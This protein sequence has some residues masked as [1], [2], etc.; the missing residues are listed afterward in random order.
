MGQVI[1][2]CGESVMVTPSSTETSVNCPSC[3]NLLTVHG[4]EAPTLMSDKTRKKIDDHPEITIDV[5]QHELATK[6]DKT[7]GADFEQ[8]ISLEDPTSPDPNLRTRALESS[9]PVNRRPLHAKTFGDYELVDEIA[10]G[11]MGVVYKAKQIRLN[12]VVA[13]KMILAGQLASS[14]EIQ[15][16]FTEAEAAAN[17]DH[18][19]IVPIYEIGEH[20]G[21]HFF[22]MAYIEGD[23]LSDQV[24]EGP[25]DPRR[26]AALTRQVADAI[27]YAHQQGVVHRDL[28]PANV[29]MDRSHQ[30]KITD[31]GLAKR[32]GGDSQLTAT[33][34][35]M[36]TPSY[37]PPEQADGRIDEVGPA[38]DIYSLGALLY[39]LLVGRPPFQ[40][41]S[42]IETLKQVLEKEPVSPRTLNSDVDVD[43]ATICLKCLEKAPAQRYATAG[44]LTAELDRYLAGQPILARPVSRANQI[45]RWCRR[46]PL[47]AGLT[48]AVLLLLLSIGIAGPMVAWRQADLRVEA[49]RA[50]EV[51][52]EASLKVSK[53]ND[54][55]VIAMDQAETAKMAAEAAANQERLAKE[56]LD[57][58]K[59]E[60]I[61]TL[62]ATSIRLAQR[63]WISNNISRAQQILNE[64]PQEF[65]NWEW[66]YLYSLCQTEE[67][68]LRG[69]AAAVDSLR[70]LPDNQRLVSYSQ[71]GE[72]KLWSLSGGREL[73]GFK[74][75]QIPADFGNSNRFSVILSGRDLEILDVA[76]SEVQAS[77]PVP[78]S[79]RKIERAI[80]SDDGSLLL[81]LVV[82]PPDGTDLR[83]LILVDVA[84]GTQRTIAKNVKNHTLFRPACSRDGTQVAAL[85]DNENVIGIWDAKSGE[86]IQALAG[87]V[88]PVSSVDFSPDGR[89]LASTGL[90]GSVT[91]WDL[92]TGT[93]KHRMKGHRDWV[94]RANFSED[95]RWLVTCG[96]D[97]TARIW[98]VSTGEELIVIRGN[99]TYVMD[100]TISSDGEL[101]A[102]AS[103]DQIVRVWEVGR[104]TKF[105]EGIPDETFST[106]VSS[107]KYTASQRE[108]IRNGMLRMLADHTSQQWVSW[109]GHGGPLTEVEFIPGTNRFI[110]GGRDKTLKVWSADERGQLKSFD[111]PGQVI[112]VGASPDGK[113]IVAAIGIADQPNVYVWDAE[114]FE[115]IHKLDQ[116]KDYAVRIDVSPDGRYLACGGQTKQLNNTTETQI[117]IWDLE[118]GEVHK[119]ISGNRGAITGLDFSP[120][121][122]HLLAAASGGT[123]HIWSIDPN[124]D[125]PQL[126]LA[127]SAT[128]L[129]YHPDGDRFASAHVDGKVRIWDVKTGE[130]IGELEGARTTLTS[131][132]YSPDGKRMIVCG[133][134]TAVTL[135]DPDRN[136]QLLE[137]RGH[138]HLV[139]DVAFSDDGN[140]IASASYDGAV[141]LW[142]SG[143]KSVSK[144]REWPVVIQE[145]FGSEGI[146]NRWS[147]PTGQWSVSEGRLVG[148]LEKNQTGGQ[149]VTVSV[150]A[151]RLT[152]ERLPESL[153]ISFDF[154][155][156]QPIGIQATL[157]DGFETGISVELLS[158]ENPY[159]LT[160]GAILWTRMGGNNYIPQGFN[161]KYELPVGRSVN[162]RVVFDAG[163]LTLYVDGDELT[164]ARIRMPRIPFLSIQGI[165]AEPGTSFSIDNVV[166]RAPIEAFQRLKAEALVDEMFA[167]LLLREDVIEK[168]TH[169]SSLDAEIK[170]LAIE[171][172]HE[173][174]LPSASDLVA[175]G[176]YIVSKNE[177][178][179]EELQRAV[180]LLQGPVRTDPQNGYYNTMLGQAYLGLEEYEKALPY[181]L[182]TAKLRYE[183]QGAA[184]P[185]QLAMLAIAYSK[186]GDQEKVDNLLDRLDPFLALEHWQDVPRF[187][188]WRGQATQLPR[189][190]RRSAAEQ[191]VL[192]FLIKGLEWRFYDLDIDRYSTCW[193][194]DASLTLGRL[195][196]PDE[197]DITANG[198]QI[199]DC[200]A[201]AMSNQLKLE[202]TKV[203][204]KIL[205]LDLDGE[206]TARVDLIVVDEVGDKFNE[207]QHRY[208]LN[209]TDEG[210]KIKR[211]RIWELRFRGAS[212]GNVSR[213]ANSYAQLDRR[214]P[215]DPK[216]DFNQI[217]LLIGAKRYREALDLTAE[218]TRLEP[219]N[220]TSW[221][222]RAMAASGAHDLGMALECQRQALRLI[223]EHFG[224]ISRMVG[225]LIAAD[226]TDELETLVVGFGCF[227]KTGYAPTL[228]AMREYLQRMVQLERLTPEEALARRQTLLDRIASK[229]GLAL[230][231]KQRMSEWF[232]RATTWNLM[233]TFPGASDF[234]GL[235][236][237][238]PPEIAPNE[239]SEKQRNTIAGRSRE[240][241]KPLGEYIDLLTEIA[242]TNMVVAYAATELES[243]LERDAVLYIGSDDAAKVWLNGEQVFTARVNRA[244]S[245]ARN[246]VP[247]RLKQGTNHLLIK[248]SQA[249]GEWGFA[250][251][252]FDPKGLPLP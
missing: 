186:I 151:A 140:S 130:R 198:D 208:E 168:L 141:N 38:A 72:V 22:S 134:D 94:F 118:T 77:I 136:L 228:H 56:L 146:F 153:D 29:L 75:T 132:A 205:E 233:G 182:Q 48:A 85:V 248:V 166:I 66:H 171:L 247:V 41:S 246:Q 155:S 15:R 70:F 163:Q 203:F 54:E 124:D 196:A 45:W 71:D 100:A 120:D 177:K 235:D 201:I 32:E 225:L 149:G 44:E 185:F 173:H 128:R 111:M 23:S 243:E 110:T 240:I 7:V 33:G 174:P 104:Y 210:W 200:L 209:K 14:E 121:S 16:F 154:Q 188:A 21:Q 206:E 99:T 20:D 36:G 53:A 1:C 31:F 187:V 229:D 195:E 176:Q 234:Q 192:E 222:L 135:W 40:A 106:F 4:E 184:E 181:L 34:Q 250:C 169:D 180:R 214:I 138:T 204:P 218:L 190:K 122:Q 35:V 232:D 51:A 221:Q 252:V 139:F 55:L 156:S 43:L 224:I 113:L 145:D 87:H 150:A 197:Y 175:V 65:R 157:D 227:E 126:T 78:A 143:R 17:L 12:R 231:E 220:L 91:L 215:S 83:E 88:L 245:K 251:E 213:D 147:R 73:R 37:M 226:R 79:P 97:R 103:A 202:S 230:E 42:P 179:R 9:S 30:P 178:T 50:A 193:A 237:K 191:E 160:K 89:L 165:Y 61:A 211:L 216:P 90:D 114:S 18:P 57:T 170:E 39:C 207:Y 82:P 26:A 69:H 115:L 158:L 242:K 59:Q 10:R 107:N 152:D 92:E 161:R 47:I 86:L 62:Y 148:V 183:Q 63:E 142:D 98:N 102:T 199:H 123:M 25:L 125:A 238:H 58:E 81:L 93:A 19:N 244:F 159:L 24:K 236:M 144:T 239:L 96:K 60:A 5:G 112:D 131:L 27:S 2:D 28:K 74:S 167:E 162:I 219:D 127:V 80:L 249:R 6:G 95:G 217:N 117:V 119:T 101:L 68:V 172:A 133:D 189:G 212:S 67:R 52:E 108:A 49:V 13:L 76:T 129:T 11:G 194:D 46:Q 223:P 64:C 105:E 116:L 109:F 8:T 84:T 164:T 3:G 241:I 137:L